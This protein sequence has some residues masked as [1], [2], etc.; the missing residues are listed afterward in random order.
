MVLISVGGGGLCAGVA[1][2]LKETNP[3]IR[4]IGV[5]PA[6]LPSMRAALDGG[7]VREVAEA[8]TLADGIAVRKVGDLTH[9]CVSRYV[10]DVI[11]I[12]EESIA[13]AILTLLEQD[14]TVAE[15][16]GAAPVAAL[17]EGRVS[18]IVG[19]KVCAVISGGNIDVNVISRII[20]RGLV[21]AGRLHRMKLV[22]TDTPGSL[23]KLLS[24]I[25]RLRAN[26]LEI[27]HDRAF[28]S[29]SAFGTVFVSLSLET[30]GREHIDDL[31]VA[32]QTE[33]YAI[34]LEE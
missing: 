32:L 26:V 4:V 1:I 3:K 15:G 20:E 7:G 30:R 22:V 13:S 28:T 27:N 5:E 11:S 18:G 9:A 17:L 16:A 25:G 12:S 29:G 2:A 8:W 10:D 24:L 34:L 23:A 21:A 31:R 6:S 14:K 33:G 19:K